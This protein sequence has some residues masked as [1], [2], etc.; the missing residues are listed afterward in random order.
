MMYSQNVMADINYYVHLI[1]FHC[2]SRVM[3][4]ESSS[5]TLFNYDIC[6]FQKSIS[7]NVPGLL[8][9]TPEYKI[10]Y[11]VIYEFD[12]LSHQTYTIKNFGSF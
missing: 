5:Q 10:I 3:M 1:M 11:D 2:N 7:F 4:I 9:L 6:L 8:E 12:S